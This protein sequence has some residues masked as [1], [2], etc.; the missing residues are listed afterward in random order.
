MN[1]VLLGSFPSYRPLDLVVALV[2]AWVFPLVL[3]LSIRANLWLL[4]KPFC[5]REAY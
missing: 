4:S 1:K 5:E 2:L 3:I